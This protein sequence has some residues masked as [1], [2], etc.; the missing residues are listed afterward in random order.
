[1]ISNVILN[2]IFF[3]FSW[4]DKANNEKR[5]QNKVNTT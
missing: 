4:V 3:F 2:H 1:M 5:W